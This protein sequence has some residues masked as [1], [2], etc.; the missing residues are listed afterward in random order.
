MSSLMRWVWK[1]IT[2]LQK[3]G[4]TVSCLVGR[5]NGEGRA[6]HGWRP[7]GDHTRSNVMFQRDVC[8]DP[9]S[10]TNQTCPLGNIIWL[11]RDS[12]LLSVKYND[13]L[14]VISEIMWISEYTGWV[15]LLMNFG[16]HPSIGINTVYEFLLISQEPWFL[17]AASPF[18]PSYSYRIRHF[19]TCTLEHVRETGE[20]LSPR[21]IE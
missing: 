19:I 17:S 5:P 12:A 18:Y 14:P 8:S 3:P 9:V 7:C 16:I 11:L 6:K 20:L 1:T 21:T 4:C 2:D 10:A 15:L 13:T